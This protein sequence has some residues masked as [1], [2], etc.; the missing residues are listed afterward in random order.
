MRALW[1]IPLIVSTAL[2]HGGSGKSTSGGGQSFGGGGVQMPGGTTTPTGQRG[3]PPVTI[4][5]GGRQHTWPMWWAYHRE[6]FFARRLRGIPISGTKPLRGNATTTRKKLR[7]D[8]LTPILTRALEDKNHH[9][10]SAAAVALGKFG[11]L[12]F[13]RKLQRHTGPPPEKWF[14]VREASLYALALLRQPHN[15]NFMTQVAGD[16]RRP[17]TARSIALTS[18]ALDR[19]E[20]S[21]VVIEWHLKYFRSGLRSSATEPPTVSEEDR[22]RFSAHLLGFVDQKFDVN[23]LLYKA[24]LGSR[25]WGDATRGLAITALGRRRAKDYTEKL[26]QMMYRRESPPAVLQSIPIALGRLIARSDKRG[27][28]RLARFAKDFRRYPAARH[29]T[30][31]ALARIGG[32]HSLDALLGYLRNNTFNSSEDRAFVYLALGMLGADFKEARETLMSE[33]ERRRT[34]VARSALALA[35]GIA[36]HKPAIPLTIR[37]LKKTSLGSGG[38]DGTSASRGRQS[39]FKWRGAD[40]LAYGSL[41]LGFHGSED[42]LAEVRRILKKYRDPKVQAN[43]ATAIVLLK[44]AHAIDDLAPILRDSGNAMTRVLRDSGNAMTRGAIVMALG[45]VPEPNMK[46]IDLLKAQYQRDSNPDSVRAMAVIGLGALGDPS[47]VPMSVYF[48][49]AYNYLIRCQALD[50]IARLL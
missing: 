11:D 20:D 26:F 32:K 6:G 7:E 21:L 22:R 41:A 3:G 47:S 37:Y 35:L 43:A 24:A 40:F 9:V 50:L 13:E 23:P 12:A 1:L 18:L 39:G 15:R 36:R 27:V 30:V 29:F 48:V 10:R 17:I 44:R 8:V 45:L 31:M 19:T 4:A 38:S 28:E 49:S 25:K 2:A 33:Y 46:V 14:D 5:S 34:I 42:G 16:K